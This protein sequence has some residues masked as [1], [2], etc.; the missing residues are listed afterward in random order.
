MRNR[1]KYMSC[2]HSAVNKLA[3]QYRHSHLYCMRKYGAYLFNV[4]L[5]NTILQYLF[6]F[7]WTQTSSAVLTDFLQAWE[8]NIC[9]T[10]EGLHITP[11]QSLNMKISSSMSCGPK[12]QFLLVGNDTN[13]TLWVRGAGR[14]TMIIKK[15]RNIGNHLREKLRNL[16]EKVNVMCCVYIVMFKF[17]LLMMYLTNHSGNLWH[18]SF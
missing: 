8:A 14:F 13:L 12:V 6:L 1:R 16:L 9:L 15:Q 5:L 10:L 2:W 17:N 11:G 4:Y 18:M 3:L 7:I